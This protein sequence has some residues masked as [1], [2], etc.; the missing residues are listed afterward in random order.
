MSTHLIRIT[1]NGLPREATVSG[2]RTLLQFLRDELR[3]TGVK[4]GCAEGDC[5]ACTVIF[6]GRAA[7]SCLILAAQADGATVTTI[8][9]LGGPRDGDM[10]PIQEAFL[11]VGAVQCGYC[12]PGMILTAKALLDADPS[13]T[14]EEIRTAISGNLCRCTGYAKIIAAIELAAARIRSRTAASSR[15]WQDGSGRQS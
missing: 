5:G 6:N 1:V 3:L 14:R 15:F 4:D 12:T 7:K 9:G 2:N 8:E 13:P 11:E 10:H